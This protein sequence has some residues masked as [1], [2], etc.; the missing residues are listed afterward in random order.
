MDR[1]KFIETSG[2]AA[3]AAMLGSVTP[4][5]KAGPAPSGAKPA[6]SRK[7]KLGLYSISYGGIWY[8]GAAL[9]FD[10]LCRYAKQYGYEGIELDNKRPMGNPMDLDQ[11]KREE[12]RNSLAASYGP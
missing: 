11:R 7:I 2:A 4:S 1:R 12:M 5:V 9:S 10:E 8:K 6:K 3:G